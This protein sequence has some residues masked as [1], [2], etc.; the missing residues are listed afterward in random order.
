LLLSQFNRV[1]SSNYT[2]SPRCQGLFGS[3]VLESSADVCLL[4][5]HSKVIRD[6]S[7]SGSFRSYLILD[8][9]RHGRSQVSIPFEISMGT[10]R[11]REGMEDEV[12]E[13]WPQR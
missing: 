8:K 5:D 13:Y 4:V 11:A 3:Q 12:A 7:G 1:T 2:E 10:L 9:N 6:L